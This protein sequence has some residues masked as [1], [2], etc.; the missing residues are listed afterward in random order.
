VVVVQRYV[1]AL[2]AALTLALAYSL[3]TAAAQEARDPLIDPPSGGAGSRFQIVG[4]SGWVPGETV[5]LS[6]TFTTSS[7]PLGAPDPAPLVEEEFTVTVLADGTWSFPLVVDEFFADAGGP[8]D[9]PGYIVV[10]TTAPSHESANA[11]VYTVRSVLPAGAEAIASTG[12]GPGA[13]S[14]ATVVVAALFA[15][16]AGGLLLLSGTLRRR[17]MQLIEV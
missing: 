6:V 5:T 17:D 2:L 14:G 10:R 15:A 11:Y 1:L 7:D 12:S 8:P 9:T 3:S 13:P 4:Q 16:G